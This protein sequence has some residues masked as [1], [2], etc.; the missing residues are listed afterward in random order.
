MVAFSRT[1][2]ASTT[3]GP[4]VKVW[5]QSDSFDFFAPGET[6]AVL[7]EKDRRVGALEPASQTA[8]ST[9]VEG[10]FPVATYVLPSMSPRA[11][12]RIEFTG[13]FYT[14]SNVGSL[15]MGAPVLKFRPRGATRWRTTG[16]ARAGDEFEF[17]VMLHNTGW[18]PIY[19]RVRIEIK[20]LQASMFKRISA[21]ASVVGMK[22]EKLAEAIVNAK[23][24]RPIQ[25]A[26]APNTTVVKGVP[27]KCG[28]GRIERVHDGIDKGG[29][30][31]WE[32]G[33]FKARDPCR[34]A[35]F[36]KY[37]VFRVVV[38]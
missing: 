34:G 29:V 15:G 37:I 11:K 30:D 18:R 16:T 10:A 25:L 20:P 1:G 27:G 9:L 28:G 4:E 24:D 6:F 26:V 8:T 5:S 17:Y 13:T 12:R 23:D 21:F 36:L 22:E 33:G 14:P 2:D 38:K 7:A 31:V 32:I 3:R 35:Q 19:A